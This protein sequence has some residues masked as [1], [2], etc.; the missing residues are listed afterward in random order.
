MVIFGCS[1]QIGEQLE[2]LIEQIKQSLSGP[3]LRFYER[4]FE[5][6]Y[7]ITDISRIIK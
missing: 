7:K 5:F 6:F 1:D 3:A 4:E 2:T